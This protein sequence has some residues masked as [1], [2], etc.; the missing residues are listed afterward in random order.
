MQ[1]HLRGITLK[2]K[3]EVKTPTEQTEEN[4]TKQNH[5]TKTKRLQLN[6]K[7]KKNHNSCILVKREV[8]KSLIKLNHTTCF[9]SKYLHTYQLWAQALI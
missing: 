9:I 7:S 6:I 5:W 8:M 1:I 4:K 2:R 3:L